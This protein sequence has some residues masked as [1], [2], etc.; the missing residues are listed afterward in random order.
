M[1]NLLIEFA[2]PIV[3][4]KRIP[5]KTYE[6]YSRLKNNYSLPNLYYEKLIINNTNNNTYG[7]ASLNYTN[8]IKIK[9]I[10]MFMTFTTI[11]W[12]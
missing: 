9:N 11:L 12:R 3:D 4:P 5:D 10:L 2:Y 7:L 6:R 8:L 1:S